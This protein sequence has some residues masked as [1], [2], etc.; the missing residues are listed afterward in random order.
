MWYGD[1]THYLVCGKILQIT[2]MKMLRWSS[3]VTCIDKIRNER[4][5][6]TI[7]VG[8]ITNKLNES[9]LRWLGHV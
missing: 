3:G 2:E 8:N 4:I 9:R 6:S 1:F 5:C 7:D